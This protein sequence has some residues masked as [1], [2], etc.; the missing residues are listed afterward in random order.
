MNV[1]RIFA[2]LFVA[3]GG[4]F[5]AAASLG[6]SHWTRVS[7][8]FDQM[9]PMLAVGVLALTVAIF[10]LGMYFEVLASVVLFAGAAASVVWGLVAGWESGVWMIVVIVLTAPMVVSGLLFMLAARMQTICTLEGHVEA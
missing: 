2:R 10:V 7:T 9:T 1:E 6:G 5:W 8:E 4:L 3:V